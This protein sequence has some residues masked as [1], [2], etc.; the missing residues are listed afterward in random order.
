MYRE[1]RKRGPGRDCTKENRVETS[2]SFFHQT[3]AATHERKEK[4]TSSGKDENKSAAEPTVI[5]SSKATLPLLPSK[6]R[7]E[8]LLIN[9]WK[10]PLFFSPCSVRIR[11]SFFCSRFLRLNEGLRTPEMR[12]VRGARLSKSRT[13]RG[14]GGR[15]LPIDEEQEGASFSAR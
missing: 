4:L 3:I 11:A 9:G 10:E 2:G 14:P 8:H 7:T 6:R 13:R 15:S 1:L 5:L 12:E